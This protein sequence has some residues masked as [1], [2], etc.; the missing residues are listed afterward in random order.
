MGPLAPKAISLCFFSKLVL[1]N[2]VRVVHDGCTC[3]ALP[4]CVVTRFLLCHI[5]ENT[6]VL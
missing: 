6:P 4:Q 1:Q 5:G 2:G 3:S